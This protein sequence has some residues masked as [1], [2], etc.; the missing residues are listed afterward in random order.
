MIKEMPGPGTYKTFDSEAIDKRRPRSYDLCTGSFV[1]ISLMS[2]ST[3]AQRFSFL[4][5]S[6]SRA[7]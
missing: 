5:R 7:S 6:V 2:G 1:R 4:F 3:F